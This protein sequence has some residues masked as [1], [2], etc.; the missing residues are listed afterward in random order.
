M[1]FLRIGAQRSAT[2]PVFPV[3]L[4]LPVVFSVPLLELFAARLVVTYQLT[5]IFH[6]H[7]ERFDVYFTTLKVVVK[8]DLW[9]VRGDTYTVPSKPLDGRTTQPM[10]TLHVWIA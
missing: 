3:N 10:A 9:D 7:M 4:L 1:I 8:L 2:L 5:R 6:G